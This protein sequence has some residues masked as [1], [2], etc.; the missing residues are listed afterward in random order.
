MLDGRSVPGLGRGSCELGHLVIDRAG[1]VCTCGRRGCVQAFASGP[2]IQ[3]RAGHLRGWDVPADE[4]RTG[5]I[6]NE[7]WAVGALESAAD[8]LATAITGAVQV[9]DHRAAAQAVGPGSG[10]V[11]QFER[12]RRSFSDGGTGETNQAEKAT[13]LVRP[14][15]PT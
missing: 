2:A 1:P 9:E 10:R 12:H 7:D 11:G 13:G 4:L 6:E 8:A 15:P 5:W 3:R 14:R